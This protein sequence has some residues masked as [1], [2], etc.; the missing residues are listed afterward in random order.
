MKIKV[1][2]SVPADGQ[3]GIDELLGDEFETIP[4]NQYCE[5]VRKEMK[6]LKQVGIMVE[7]CPLT[8]NVEEY[9]EV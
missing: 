5:D 8:L 4:Y 7:G 3:C 1:I 6:K 9:K 2:A